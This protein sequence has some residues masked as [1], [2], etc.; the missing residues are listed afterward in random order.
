MKKK[1]I[2]YY[3]IKLGKLQQFDLPLSI[4]TYRNTKINIFKVNPKSSCVTL[5][6]KNKWH[7]YYC[8]SFINIKCSFSFFTAFLFGF[9]LFICIICLFWWI[10]ITLL[11]ADIWHEPF[12]FGVRATGCTQL[13]PQLRRLRK[14]CFPFWWGH[15]SSTCIGGYTH[16]INMH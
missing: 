8:C 4:Q 11:W 14:A 6:N 1:V 13:S 5:N 10:F 15:S 3:V 12:L 7:V 2:K 16:G 9:F